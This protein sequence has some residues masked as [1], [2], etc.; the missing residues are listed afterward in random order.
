MSPFKDYFLGTIK[1]R[2]AQFEGRARRSEYWY[3]TLF[4]I[5]IYFILGLLSGLLSGALMSGTDSALGLMPMAL[6]GIFL[7]AIIIPSI[8]LVVRRLHDTGKSGWW[9]FISLIPF[10]GSIVI[11]VFLCTDSQ[12][13]TNE[14]GPNPKE[15]GGATASDHLIQDYS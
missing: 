13:G 10:V 8:A 5:I 9:Y 1:N 6:I 7:L 3:F 4:V 12:S 15:I 11:I 2:Y 14:Y